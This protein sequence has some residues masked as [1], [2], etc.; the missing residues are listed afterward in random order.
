MSDPLIEIETVPL[1]PERRAD[2]HK[3]RFGHLLV[4]AGSPRMTGAAL[5]ACRAGLR[6]GAGLVTL[7]VPAAVHPL[8]APAMLD[9][10]SLPLPG[11][12]SG[13]FA[14]DAI[15]P[16]LDFVGG[17]EAVVLGPGITTEDQTVEFATRVAQ[18]ART[19]LVLD[20]DGLNC[21]AKVPSSLRA[22]GGPRIL[23]PHPGEAA[24]LL[25]AKVPEVQAD[26]VGAAR[27]LSG[28]FGAVVAL[29]GA[30][31]VVTDGTRVYTNDTGN[32]GM[33]TGGSG[34]VL[35]GLLG[36]LLA[37]G[38]EP[39][40]AAVLAVHLHGLAGDLAARKVGMV[41][42]VA[43]DLLDAIGPALLAL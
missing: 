35:T 23:T 25:P 10:M 2:D 8:I 43:S 22:A 28:K 19:P 39:F 24:R 32:P 14:R 30:G 26:R 34:D 42:L 38:M 5:L 29:K 20:A 33:A 16:T 6:G 36:G 7:G 41:S 27:E 1:P 13:A 15:Q 3:G 4:L 17:V 11:T 37:Q 12:A 31:T 40:D 9:C 21:L 18:R